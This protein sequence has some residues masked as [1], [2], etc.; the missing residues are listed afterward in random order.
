MDWIDVE[1]EGV[2]HFGLHPNY[3]P[4]DNICFDV[5]HLCCAITWRLMSNLWKFMM[6]QAVEL[7]LE[8]TERLLEKFW[9]M[10]NI[11]VWNFN[12]SFACFIGSELLTLI[13][14]IPKIIEFLKEKF[15][16]TKTLKSLCDGLSLWKEITPVISSIEDS[17]KIQRKEVSV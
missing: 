6:I 15:Y 16:L 12:K 14:N 3:L 11:M 9:T 1:N 7:I 2:S 5:F 10:Y 8:F 13:T 17:E 4:R